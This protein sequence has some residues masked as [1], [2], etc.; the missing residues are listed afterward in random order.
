MFAIRLYIHLYLFC[1][2]F[3]G[4]GSL[5]VKSLQMYVPVY[6]LRLM[7]TLFNEGDY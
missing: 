7:C 5:S 4:F 6:T 3:I 1:I 2:V